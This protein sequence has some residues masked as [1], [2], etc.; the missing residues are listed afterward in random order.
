MG[1]KMLGQPVA[2]FEEFEIV[3]QPVFQDLGI[4]RPQF[5]RRQGIEHIRVDQH[6]SRLMERADQILPRAGIDRGLAADR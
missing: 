4:S 3:D 1:G 5:A 6:Q 2:P